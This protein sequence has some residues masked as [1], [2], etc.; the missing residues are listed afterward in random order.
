MVTAGIG[1]VLYA[2]HVSR[3]NAAF[4]VS[5]PAKAVTDGQ[6]AG[7]AAANTEGGNG[8]PADHR[9]LSQGRTGARLPG[10]GRC[11]PALIRRRRGVRAVARGSACPVLELPPGRRRRRPG[12]G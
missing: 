2:V 6:V 3:W 1:D 10:I 12:C 11:T 4:V 9:S 8:K 7:E 5:L